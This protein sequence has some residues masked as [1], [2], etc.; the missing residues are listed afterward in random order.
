M[1]KIDLCVMF[2]DNNISFYFFLQSK[3]NAKI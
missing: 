3:N 2:D 1:Y